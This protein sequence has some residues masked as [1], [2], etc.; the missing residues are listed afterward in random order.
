MWDRD[1]STETSRFPWSRCQISRSH[2]NNFFMWDQE[3][4]QFLRKIGTFQLKRPDLMRTNSSGEIGRFRTFFREDFGGTGTQ[5]KH[6]KQNSKWWNSAKLAQ[7]YF[8]ID[9]RFLGYSWKCFMYYVFDD[10]LFWGLTLS[11]LISC[12]FSFSLLSNLFVFGPEE[13]TNSYE[14]MD[15]TMKFAYGFSMWE[16]GN[17]YMEGCSWEQQ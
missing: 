5:K 2:A 11:L 15:A 17:G 8:K 4:L 10:H 16:D 6:R 12:C 7:N 13:C 1:V 9:F 3:I 14:A